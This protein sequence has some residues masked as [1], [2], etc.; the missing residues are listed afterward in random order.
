MK[1]LN[2]SIKANP[3]GLL[4]SGLAAAV[5]VYVAFKDGAIRGSRGTTFIKFRIRK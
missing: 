4:L 1:A 3:I 5:A 2:L